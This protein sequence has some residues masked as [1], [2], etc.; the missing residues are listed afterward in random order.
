MNR[1]LIVCFGMIVLLLS[2]GA[3]TQDLK[4]AG[5]ALTLIAQFAD[6]IC[7]KVPLQG[8]SNSVELTGNAKAEVSKLLRVLTELG[9]QGAGKYQ[10][11]Q[12][13]GLLQKDLKDALKDSATCKQK[14]FEDLKDRL[15]P[16][17]PPTAST[18]PKWG[19][20]NFHTSP[21]RILRELADYRK[22][23]ADTDNSVSTDAGT[24]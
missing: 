2:H 13:E 10:S 5:E 7:T 24:T 23:I 22:T 17:M 19:E 3:R 1:R 20:A 9:I 12:Y 11:G 14:I 15:L 8:S 6:S 4:K 21:P 18:Y 16:T